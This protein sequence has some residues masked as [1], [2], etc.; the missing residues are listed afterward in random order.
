[1]RLALEFWTPCSGT[2][3]SVF[4]TSR[5]SSLA[6]CRGDLT[7]SAPPSSSHGLKLAPRIAAMIPPD[8]GRPSTS[9]SGC[10]PRATQTGHL[11]LGLTRTCPV[12]FWPP[13]LCSCRCTDPPMGLRWT[14][15]PCPSCNPRPTSPKTVLRTRLT[16]GDKRWKR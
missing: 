6:D 14:L 12:Q 9:A 11:S 13:R 2:P 10:E 3:A 1:M 7:L 15:V 4:G 5:A 16:V 8:A